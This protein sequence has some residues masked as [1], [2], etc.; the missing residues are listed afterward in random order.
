MGEEMSENNNDFITS[1][2]W[3]DQIK[4]SSNNFLVKFNK[5]NNHKLISITKYSNKIQAYTAYKF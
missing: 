3:P 2:I 5:Y 1:A 4:D